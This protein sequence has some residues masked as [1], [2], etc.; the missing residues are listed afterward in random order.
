MNDHGDRLVDE[1]ALLRAWQLG[2]SESGSLLL[3][4]YTEPLYN[5]FLTKTDPTTAEELTQGTFEACTRHHA[6]LGEGGTIRAYLFAIARKKVLQHRDE[7]RRRGARYDP[8]QH[9]L[10]ANR[11]SP[12]VAVARSQQQDLIVSALQRLPLDFQISIELHYWEDMSVREIA[13]V[14]EIPP[15]TVKSRLHRAREMLRAHVE[16]LAASPELAHETVRGLE[17]WIGS[18]QRGGGSR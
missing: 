16:A 2:D 5:F 3:R 10:V 12:S 1:F 4:R 9:S 8:L 11:T 15:G 18:L 6:E 14:L 7:W 17:H 13:R